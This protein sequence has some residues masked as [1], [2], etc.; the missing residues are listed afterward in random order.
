[1]YSD[2][3]SFISDVSNLCPLFL[4]LARHLSILFIFS[5][6][7]LLVLLVFSIDLLFLIS[8]IFAL[9]WDLLEL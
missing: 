1:M 2:V 6:K 4:N 5:K 8:F 3:S 7:Q 9:F